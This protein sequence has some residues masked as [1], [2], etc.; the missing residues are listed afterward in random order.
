MTTS[1]PALFARLNSNSEAIIFWMLALA[2]LVPVWAFTYLPTQDGPCHINN[3]QIIKDCGNP[4]TLYGD[5]F[6]VRLEPLPNLTSHLALT[7]LLY[8][9]AP[10][11]AEKVLVSIYVLGFAASYRFFLG[12]FGPRCVPLSWVGLLLIYQRCFW[13]GFYNYCLGLI[14]LWIVVGLCLRWRG[15]LNVLHLLCLTLL[16]TA[17][18]F[19]HLAI[20]LLAAL[21][22]LGTTLLTSPR[23]LLAPVIVTIA[24]LPA[25]FLTVDYF[26]QTG[27][28]R[29]DSGLRLVRDPLARLRG[30]EV[31]TTLVQD[32]AAI[33]EELFAHHVG[34]D[35]PGTLVLTFYLVLLAI[36]T[37][38]EARAESVD[39]GS[40]AGR[41]FPTIFGLLLFAAYFLTAND[42]SEHG[43]FLKTRLAPLFCL[44]W[45]ACLRESTHLE[46]RLFFRILAFVLIVLNLLLVTATVA[47]GNRLLEQYTAGIET[48]GVRQRLFVIQPDP[49]PIPPVNPTLHAAHYYCL[50]TGNINLDNY[51]AETLHFPVKYRPGVR[52]GRTFWNSYPDKEA[53]DVILS[54]QAEGS[55]APRIPAGWNQVFNQGALR[56][57]HRAKTLREK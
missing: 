6:E 9:F 57:F 46:V 17:A 49:R 27:I 34:R 52:R 24:A 35:L 55:A 15:R 10:L 14:L 32:L 28:F 30:E 33:D 38:L 16:F 45:L 29:A 12:A 56:I 2:H 43:G 40:N 20:Y 25:A 36:F 54:W 8:V 11:I 51:E 22:A 31:R 53:V 37:G 41:L 13:M 44:V 48:V 5:F 18:Y 23:R 26:Q 21:G 50:G 3:A 47:A 42:L 7:A 39:D 1:T 4:E 19:T